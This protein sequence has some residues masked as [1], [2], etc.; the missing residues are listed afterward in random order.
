MYKEIFNG[1][2]RGTII[3]KEGCFVAANQGNGIYGETIVY[4]K[5]TLSS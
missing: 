1:T 2:Q 3:S 5:E 4:E